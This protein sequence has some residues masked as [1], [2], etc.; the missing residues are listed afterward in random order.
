MMEANTTKLFR[1]KLELL[2]LTQDEAILNRAKQVISAYYL[3]FRQMSYGDVLAFAGTTDHQDLQKSQLVLMVQ[4]SDELLPTFSERV[5]RVLQALP[6]SRLV[7]I[8]SPSLS[9]E[10]LEG[11]QNPRVTP[12]SQDEFYHTIKFD[13]M[14]LYRCRAQYVDIA[15]EDLF[16]M[17]A[18]TFPVFVRLHLNQRY[19]AAAFSHCVLSDERHQRLQRAREIYI[20]HKDSAAYLDY[21]MSY[22]DG[23]GKGLRKRVRALFR[24]L[25]HDSLY[26]NEVL[27]FDFRSAPVETFVERY[28]AMRSRAEE[29]LNMLSST[30][31]FWDVIRE[32]LEGDF[33][34]LW[35]APWIAVYGAI[36]AKRSGKGDPF[37]VLMAGLLME[38]GLFD[39]EGNL[40]RSYLLDEERQAPTGSENAFYHHSIHSL[41]RCLLRG[42]PLSETLK[43]VLVCVHERNDE[44][45]YPNQVPR[46][47]LPVEGQILA[48]AEKIDQASLTTMKKT[49]VGFRFLREKIWEAEKQNPGAFSVEFLAA[50]AESLL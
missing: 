49:G 34:L 23:A 4:E 7:T 5:D 33:Y 28:E 42:L 12:L 48:F 35:R 47:K 16:S 25:Y 1:Q 13:Y 18:L 21:I 27:I 32:A 17:T 24:A 50:I 22:Y 20:R 37:L 26:L 29:L 36:I 9:R 14:A 43:S 8:M 11:T 38:V 45:G 30:E 15:S 19:L 3:T 10:N 41:N 39:V 2:L 40:V 6:R 31:D 44:K 46:D